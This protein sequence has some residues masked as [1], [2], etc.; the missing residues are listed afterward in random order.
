MRCCT[1]A[2]TG[3]TPRWKRKGV[4]VD[5]D[6]CEPIDPG[7]ETTAMVELE[8][9]GQEPLPDRG[10]SQLADELIV[11]DLLRHSKMIEHLGNEAIVFFAMSP[12]VLAFRFSR[13]VC[14]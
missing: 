11:S 5:H 14:L 13:K 12:P 4:A 3:S 7:L 2:S 8:T 9:Y 1:A 6:L 10:L